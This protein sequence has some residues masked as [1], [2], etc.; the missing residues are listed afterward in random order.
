[1]PYVLSSDNKIFYDSCGTGTPL[2]LINGFG[3]PCDWIEQFYLPH[4]KTDFHC[5][6][7]DLRGIGR[8]SELTPDADYTLSAHAK[9]VIAVLDALGW[10]SAHIWGASFGA[11]LSLELVSSYPERVRALA[12]AAADA[13]M[14]SVYQRAYANIY[15]ARRIYFNGLALQASDPKKAAEDMLTAY[16]P[17][18]WH[19]TN[20]RVDEVRRA[21]IT[22]FKERPMKQLMSPFKDIIEMEIRSADLPEKPAQKANDSDIYWSQLEGLKS[23]AHPVLLLQGYSDMLVHRDAAFYVAGQLENVELR[24]I[25]PAAHSFAISDEHL[26]GMAAWLKRREQDYNGQIAKAV[27][28]APRNE[29]KA[30]RC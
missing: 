3:P 19:G 20:P 28:G 26:E 23:I 13:G 18:A 25:K 9:D 22:M 11:A 5:A 24:L 4:F 15:D 10:D 6:W 7:F 29:P 2:L 27:P 14:P 16:F 21:L 8:S 12:I 30:A 17:S 1:M